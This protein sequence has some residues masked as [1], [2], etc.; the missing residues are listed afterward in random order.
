MIKR[1]VFCLTVWFLLVATALN[2]SLAVQRSS[3]IVSAQ[4]RRT[5]DAELT[6]GTLE[7]NAEYF[8]AIGWCS[9]KSTSASSKADIFF[10]NLEET[11]YKFWLN[12]NGRVTR[13][14]LVSSTLTNVLRLKRGSRYTERYRSGDITAE[15]TYIVVKRLPEGTAHTATV[16]VTK[17]NQSKTVKAVGDCGG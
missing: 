11:P 3:T 1:Y 7:E 8:D 10:I 4:S 15:I 9:F 17:G 2:L 13:L 12:I 14:K 16:V 6:I 5:Q